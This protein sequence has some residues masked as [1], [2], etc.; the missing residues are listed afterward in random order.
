MCTEEGTLTQPGAGGRG[1]GRLSGVK[2]KLSLEG[3]CM[4]VKSS[5]VRQRDGVADRE[6]N[7]RKAERGHAVGVHGG[8]QASNI[9]DCALPKP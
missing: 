6:D 4:G 3:G 7:L 5:C 2:P 8:L 1:L 9:L